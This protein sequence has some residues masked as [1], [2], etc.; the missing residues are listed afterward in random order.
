MVAQYVKR[1]STMPCESSGS[2]SCGRV[3][4]RWRKTSKLAKEVMLGG[5]CPSYISRVDATTSDGCAPNDA[6]LAAV[7]A[8][9]TAFVEKKRR[10]IRAIEMKSSRIRGRGIAQKG[11]GGSSNSQSALNPIVNTLV[12]GSQRCRGVGPTP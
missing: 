8:H 3:H 6:S 7:A 10:P 2:H 1:D 9:P 11:D 12:R 5:S 4:Q